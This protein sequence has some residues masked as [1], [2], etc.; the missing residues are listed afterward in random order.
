MDGLEPAA[1]GGRKSVEN[2]ASAIVGAADSMQKSNTPMNIATIS[3]GFE[4]SDFLVREE[5]GQRVYFDFFEEAFNYI[6]NKGY[7]RM[8][9]EEERDWI[10]LM[11]TIHSSVKGGMRFNTGKLLMVFFKYKPYMPRID[12]YVQMSTSLKVNPSDNSIAKMEK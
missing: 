9:S 4:K 3:S 2:L 7:V 6:S 8:S 10:D 11:G 12:N 1:G 5:K